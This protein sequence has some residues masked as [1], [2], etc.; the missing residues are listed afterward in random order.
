MRGESES[1]RGKTEYE[2][3]GVIERNSRK[4][5]S[6]REREGKKG[7]KQRKETKEKKLDPARIRFMV[8]V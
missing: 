2:R 5:E 8:L 7:K 3:E 6:E 4:K 1:M